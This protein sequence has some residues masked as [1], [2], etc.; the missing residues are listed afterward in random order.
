MSRFEI[1]LFVFHI[2]RHILH[3]VL[4]PAIKNPAQVVQNHGF[5]NHI[6]PKPVELGFIN[7]IVLD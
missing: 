5:D 1:L 4:N 6:F 7:A 2:V 3:N